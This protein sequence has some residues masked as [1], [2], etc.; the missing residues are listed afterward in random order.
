MAAKNNSRHAMPGK[1]KRMAAA[2]RKTERECVPPY[3][4][5][6]RSKRVSAMDYTAEQFERAKPAMVAAVCLRE[7]YPMVWQDIEAHALDLA[8]KGQR[9]SL[10][11]LLEC[12]KQKDFID[13]HGNDVH[14][15]NDCA[16]IFAR[17]LIAEHPELSKR[18]ITRRSIFDVLAVPCNA[19]GVPYGDYFRRLV[20]VHG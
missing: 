12:A 15:T 14:V 16:A 7:R 3:K 8:T 6:S 10:Q 18:I 11:Y 19:E 5:D 9:I 2:S 20:R 1:H 17:W 13:A 4:N